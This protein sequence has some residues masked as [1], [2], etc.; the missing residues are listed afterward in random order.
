MKRSLSQW[1][2]IFKGVGKSWW[3]GIKTAFRDLPKSVGNW[4]T[5][6]V[7]TLANKL[8]DWTTEFT[9]WAKDVVPDVMEELRKLGT[10]IGDWLVNDMPP[11]MREKLGELSDVFVT[12][13]KS[14]PGKITRA[15]SNSQKIAQFIFKWGPLIMGA[16]AAIAL[17]IVL[18]IPVLFSGIGF[19]IQLVIVSALHQMG[20]AAA[21]KLG[22]IFGS[23]RNKIRVT[24]DTMI[25]ILATL[26]QR[27]VNWLLL[28]KARA[29]AQL[30]Q[31]RIS[32]KNKASTAATNFINQMVRLS[33]GVFNT[34]TG[35]NVSSSAIATQMKNGVVNAARGLKNTTLRTLNSLRRGVIQAFRAAHA[36]AAAAWDKL[37]ASTRKPVEYVVNTVYNQGIRGVW[38]KVAGL[39]DMPKLAPVRFAK[40]GVMPGYTPGRD[41][42]KFV[43]PTGGALELSGGESILR[44]EV[45][46]AWGA[47]TTNMLNSAAR[48]GGVS[49]VKN[50]LGF[51]NGGIYGGSQAFAKGGILG[52]LDGFAQQAKDLFPDTTLR[53]ASSSILNPLLS[54]MD[55]FKGSPWGDAVSKLPQQIVGKFLR[56]LEKVVDPKL[57]GDASKVIKLARS[58]VGNFGGSDYSNEFTRAFG[59]NGLPW[60]AMFVSKIFKDAKASKAING[61]WSAAVA[62]FNGGMQH[63]SR[64][65]VR[66][67]DLATYRGSGH[68][69]II[70]DPKRGETVGG[71]ESDAVRKQYGYMNSATAYLRSKFASGGIYGRDFLKQDLAQNGRRHTSPLLQALRASNGIPM[72]DNGGILKPGLQMVYNGTKRPKTIR[73]EAQEERIERLVR[74]LETG[75]HGTTVNVTP[76]PATVGELVN[77]VDYALRRS[78]RGGMYRR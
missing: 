52:K 13:A 78:R 65:S 53:K 71:N 61:I 1:V 36:G 60:C 7:P 16:L 54:N 33:T 49:G 4:I 3:D 41:P 17:A 47:G 72:Y 31:W 64:G 14:L 46:R 22:E 58:K 19:A 66:P 39:V 25:A 69:N 70:T 76:P 45:T 34:F 74:L 5:E 50:A 35:M 56:W 44:P 28:M 15:V 37:R 73:T 6:A 8:A 30:E 63:V 27:V 23:W 2:D 32:I 29:L 11:L 48:S 77:G 10:E 62:S 42:H 67:G 68:I 12:W 18:A 59:M 9:D 21:T 38:N 20:K 75:G 40:G 24:T 26:P 51:A 57:G 55:R 43:S